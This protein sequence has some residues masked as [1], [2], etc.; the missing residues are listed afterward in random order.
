VATFSERTLSAGAR[1][2]DR[3]ARYASDDVQ[4]WEFKE[5][6]KEFKSEII[7][8]IDLESIEMY[9]EID[10]KTDEFLKKHGVKLQIDESEE[11]DL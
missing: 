10:K 3:I 8:S 1:V 6:I 4:N 9:D 5:E 2:M 11:I 7:E